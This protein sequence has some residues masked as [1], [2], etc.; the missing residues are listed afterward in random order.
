MSNS[1]GKLE[2]L[3]PPTVEQRSDPLR[4]IG[5]N[6]AVS[7]MDRRGTAH[8]H[9]S[10]LCHTFKVPNSIILFLQGQQLLVKFHWRVVR[11]A[12]MRQDIR[13]GKMMKSERAVTSHHSLCAK[14]NACRQSVQ[15]TTI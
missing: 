4:F 13:N 1:D 12:N 14:R 10:C 8:A 11:A 6:R 15:R 7:E 9:T 2:P 5:L 3:T